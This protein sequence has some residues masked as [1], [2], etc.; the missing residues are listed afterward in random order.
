MCVSRRKELNRRANA[1][2]ITPIALGEMLYA[3]PVPC[4]R[5]AVSKERSTMIKRVKFV[6][7]PVQNIE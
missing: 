4:E 3:R 7:V 2:A 1:I 5:S 6:G